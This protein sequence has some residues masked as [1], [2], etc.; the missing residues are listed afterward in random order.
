MQTHYTDSADKQ[1]QLCCIVVEILEKQAAFFCAA[2][3][4]AFCVLRKKRVAPDTE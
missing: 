1:C 3:D 4:D 2:L